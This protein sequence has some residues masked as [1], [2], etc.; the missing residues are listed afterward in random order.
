MEEIQKE[1]KNKYPIGCTYISTNE[2]E[3]KLKDDSCTYI[4]VGKQIWAH[5]GGGYLYEDGKWAELVS[6]P[7]ENI[8]EVPEYIEAID[9]FSDYFIQ[10]K[11]YKVKNSNDLTSAVLNCNDLVNFKECDN[12]YVNLIKYRWKL[13]TKEAYE[14]Q[15]PLSYEAVSGCFPTDKNMLIYDEIE[16]YLSIASDYRKEIPIFAEKEFDIYGPTPDIE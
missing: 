12:L 9:S 1:C 7:E 11:I 6:L 13:S 14:Q 16:Q 5:F 3:N 10:G 2:N 4:I 15:K 8:T